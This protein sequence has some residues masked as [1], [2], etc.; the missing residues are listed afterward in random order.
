MAT[1][2]AV[3]FEQH[4]VWTSKNPLG[5]DKEHFLVF[6]LG[7]AIIMEYLAFIYVPVMTT[8]V[9]IMSGKF[10]S[11][12]HKQHSKEIVEGHE[13]PMWGY[14]D[15]GN[16]YYCRKLPYAMWYKLNNTYRVQNNFLESITYAIIM[17]LAAGIKYPY[18]SACA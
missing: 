6:L 1:V 4:F 16:G 5:V 8:R 12:F 11:Q 14:P 2:Q 9:S 13:A 3:S 18:Y 10:M 15:T 7:L 17:S